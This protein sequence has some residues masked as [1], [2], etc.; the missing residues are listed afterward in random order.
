MKAV[1]GF[2][3]QLAV[4]LALVAC[5]ACM[6][7]AFAGPLDRA[8]LH[9]E[10]DKPQATDYARGEEMV[11]TLSLQGA[12]RLP[13]DEYFITWERTGDD[14]L[15]DCGL[16]PA[17]MSLVIRTSMSQPGLVRILAQV[18]RRAGRRAVRGHDGLDV[19]RLRVHDAEDD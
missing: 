6:V 15:T 1:N 14:G 9:G 7:G 5:S 2:S 16:A 11:F 13:A 3:R 17:E 12:E 8:V 18:V 4:A 10:T 19:P